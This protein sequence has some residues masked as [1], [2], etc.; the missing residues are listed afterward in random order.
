[1]ILGYIIQNAETGEFW[2]RRSG[3]GP[4]ASAKVYT[5]KT[6]A[7][8]AITCHRN[9][10]RWAPMNCRVELITMEMTEIDR[11][12]HEALEDCPC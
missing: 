11:E 5:K 3:W 1:M 7:K 10:G 9:K 4:L 2:A 6:H 12:I 8:S